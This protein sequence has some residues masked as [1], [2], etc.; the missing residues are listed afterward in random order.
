[1]KF[2]FVFDKV[3]ASELSDRLPPAQLEEVLGGLIKT[4]SKMVC[5]DFLK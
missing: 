2:L 5:L 4:L 3:L 1:L